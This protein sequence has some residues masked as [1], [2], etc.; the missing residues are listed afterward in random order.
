MRCCSSAEILAWE[1]T[2]GQQMVVSTP[3]R[4]NAGLI[5]RSRLKKA[6]GSPCP[7]PTSN[8]SMPPYAF[9]CDLASS[10]PGKPGRPG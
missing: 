4:L 3:P 7:L 6:D 9:I 10:C 5:M 2:A 8:E 1:V